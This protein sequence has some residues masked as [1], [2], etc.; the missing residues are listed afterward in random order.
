MKFS[1]IFSRSRIGFFFS[2]ICLVVLSGCGG[3]ADTRTH[4]LLWHQR[5]SPERE[6]FE[7]I[8]AR[9]NAA[10][11]DRVVEPLYHNTEELRSLFIVAT[12]AGQ[13]PDL[14]YG[15]SDNVGV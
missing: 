2:A 8:I 13:G 9:Y 1:Q 12:A 7:E 11:P 4:V 10:Y 3:A 6:V 5:G 15:P 14:V